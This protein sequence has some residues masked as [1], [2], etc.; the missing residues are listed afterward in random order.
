MKRHGWTP[1]DPHRKGWGDWWPYGL[2]GWRAGIVA[3]GGCISVLATAGPEPV[4]EGLPPLVI[5]GVSARAHTQGLEVV[6]GVYWVTARREDRPEKVPLLLRSHVGADHWEV[7]I[8]PVSDP[9]MDHPGGVQSDG[10]RLW[11]PVAESR[12]KGRSVVQAYVLRDL[13]PGRPARPEREFPVDDHI[14]AVAVL[15]DPPRL[16][17]ANWDTLTVYQWDDTGRLIRS[18]SGP[19]LRTLGLGF[20]ETHAG[21]TVQDW[22]GVGGRLLAS[23]LWRGPGSVRP[24]PAS[25]LVWFDGRGES[26]G[27]PVM[28]VPGLRPGVELSREGMAVANGWIHWL[29][30]DLGPTNR[31]FRVPM[32]SVG[33][34]ESAKP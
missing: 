33:T 22:K 29:P 7:W 30:E 14:G 13:V 1:V 32:P 15:V 34:S 4:V 6:D 17:G 21:L 31:V 5:D 2:C 24:N 25:R 27:V 20:G 23:G 11:I 16:L 28:D 18:V 8:L 9:A 10:R 26:P 19:A 12:P 3:L